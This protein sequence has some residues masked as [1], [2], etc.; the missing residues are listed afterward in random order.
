MFV[1]RSYPRRVHASPTF[2][3][4][5]F[6]INSYNPKHTCE[7]LNIVS[8]AISRWI[9]EKFKAMV[10]ITPDILIV[11]IVDELLRKYEAK[12]LNIRLYKARTNALNIVGKDHELNYSK[13]YNYDYLILHFN[14]GFVALIEIVKLILTKKP[15]FE[16]FFQCFMA[17]R[18]IIV[19]L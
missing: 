16:R 5:T 8:E 2:N 17:Q 19:A 4:V 1:K 12:Y 18:V 3:G 10:I 13:L 9:A 15:H 11:V 7:R 6:Q 14:L